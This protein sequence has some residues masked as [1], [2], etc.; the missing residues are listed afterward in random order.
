VT[1]GVV[2]TGY[3]IHFA[4]RIGR[5]GR[6]GAQHY[7]GWASNVEARVIDHRRGNG[8]AIMAEVSRRGIDWEVVRL[9]PGWTRHDER[10]RKRAGHFDRDCPV[11]TPGEHK[12]ILSTV[13]SDVAKCAACGK[14][15]LY[16]FRTWVHDMATMAVASVEVEDVDHLWIDHGGEG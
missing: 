4:E 15:M 8:A 5:E 16:R 7:I 11:C 2:G 1:Q 10:R 9:Y 14:H 13:Y 3:L 12:P 6:N